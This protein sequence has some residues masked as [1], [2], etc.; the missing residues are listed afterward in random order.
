MQPAQLRSLSEDSEIGRLGGVPPA[1]RVFMYLQVSGGLSTSSVLL[2]IG[3]GPFC[4]NGF[5]SPRHL[6]RK[7]PPEQPPFPKILPCPTP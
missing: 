5:W 6:A 7:S 3:W 2:S 4:R 1:E